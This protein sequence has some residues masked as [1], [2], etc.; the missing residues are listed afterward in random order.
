[1]ERGKS[2]KKILGLARSQGARV[3]GLIPRETF[4]LS[5]ASVTMDSHILGKSE[6]GLIMSLHRRGFS[7]VELLVVIAII[8]VLIGLL[9]PA[10]QKAREAAARISCGNNLKQIGLAL[11]HH[12]DVYGGFP[13]GII[14]T[15]PD[16]SDADATGFTLLLP[17]LEQENLRNLYQFDR[18]WFD[19][20]NY[21]AVGFEVRTYFCPSN[22][23]HGAISLDRI[24]QQWKVAL[25]PKAASCDYAF[26]RGATGSLFPDEHRLPIEVRG[27]FGIRDRDSAHTCVT[28]GQIIDG[29][30]ST[31]AIGDAA[32]GTPTLRVRDLKNPDR[33]ALTVDG[34]PAV[35]EQSWGAAGITDPTQPYYGSVFATT[36]QFGLDP[37][38][39]DEPMNRP[40]LTPTIAGPDRFGDNRSG[41]DWI[42]GFRSLHP[43]G[44]NFVF[45]DGSVHF[46]RHSI[47][48][49]VYRSLS[50]I[51]GGEVVGDYE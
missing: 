47:P 12:H 44:C 8:A 28:I 48:P 27:P 21:D 11:H 15:I 9:L 7:L 46:L 24:A 2:T 10:V 34:Q 36:A 23:I 18:P 31:I 45:C 40:L 37:D 22:R 1:M 30:S 32:G 25:P 19:P 4:R 29:T 38:P 35:I 33:Q 3:R 16:M 41:K 43:G 39:R 49:A 13:A 6:G 17:F 42:S 14:A 51:A 20:A 5:A 26:C 50:T